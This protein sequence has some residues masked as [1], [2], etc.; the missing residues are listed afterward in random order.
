[1]A[2]AARLLLWLYLLGCAMSCAH[3]AEP[4]AATLL[5]PEAHL[6][7]A[8]ALFDQG[9]GS[10]AAEHLQVVLELAPVASSTWLAGYQ[11]AMAKRPDLFAQALVGS[12][13]PIPLA[14]L[15]EDD[16]AY[17][18]D[19]LFT[20]PPL[21][22]LLSALDR[23]RRD[24]VRF[25]LKEGKWQDAVHIIEDFLAS[26]VNN[27]PGLLL[28]ANIYERHD[29]L[30]LAQTRYD[31]VV[32]KAG[33]L[34]DKTAFASLFGIFRTQYRRQDFKSAEA[35]LA[36]F[37]R[38]SKRHLA[39]ALERYRTSKGG[40]DALFTI[41]LEGRRHMVEGLNALGILKAFRRNNKEA[42][43][44]FEQAR[45][46]AG[47]S[48]VLSLNHAILM[49]RLLI[50][51][52]ARSVL[53]SAGSGLEGL[54][55]ALL[56]QLDRSL[57]SGIVDLGVPLTFRELIRNLQA[58]VRVRQA[59]FEWHFQNEK[60]VAA[61]LLLQAANIA[62]KSAPA[63]YYYGL[64]LKEDDRLDDAIVQFRTALAVAPEGLKLRAEA[65]KRIDEIFE[66]QALRVQQARTRDDQLKEHF[67]QKLDPKQLQIL[68]RD[69]AE[70]VEM[71]QRGE[72]PKAREY[73]RRLSAFHKDNLE[74]YRN[75]GFANQEMGFFKEALA[76][77]DQ[78]L[79]INA[80]DPWTISQ[81]AVALYDYQK[82]LPN[83]LD[84]AHQAIR[85]K[86]DDAG[87]MANLGW[88][89]ALSGD[90]RQGA[91]ILETA[92]QKAPKDPRAHFRLAMVYYN[93]ALYPFALT[94]FS[95]TVVL[96]PRHGPANVFLG[97]TL[98]RLGKVSDAIDQL[99]RSIERVKDDPN[100][101]QLVQD[102]LILLKGGTVSQATPGVKLITDP[103]KAL[104][105]EEVARA[106]A[107]NARLATARDMIVKGEV[108]PAREIILN[109]HREFPTAA[110]VSFVYAFLLMQTGKPAD[111]AEAKS[112]L[113]GMV[114]LNSHEARAYHSLAHLL[115][116]EGKLGEFMDVMERIQ[117]LPDGLSFSDTLEAIAQ[118]WNQVLDLNPDDE[119]VIEPLALVRLHQGRLLEARDLLAKM[120]APAGQ[121]LL[122]E[123]LV[124][125]YVKDRRP[126]SF[127]EAKK[128]LAAG[129]YPAME[130]LDALWTRVSNPPI[131]QIEQVVTKEIRQLPA[132]EL[133][134]WWRIK[135]ETKDIVHEQTKRVAKIDMNNT[136]VF[137]R[138]WRQIDE[139]RRRKVEKVEAAKFRQMVDAQREAAELKERESQERI[140]SQIGGN[141]QLPRAP[142]S[143]AIAPPAAALIIPDVEE[144]QGKQLK[145]LALQ[146]VDAGVSMVAAGHVSDAVAAFRAALNVDPRS[147]EATLSLCLAQVISGQG[148]Q[149]RPMLKRATAYRDT[150]L[151]SLL[152]GHVAWRAGD[153]GTAARHWGA[154]G[155]PVRGKLK[156]AVRVAPLRYFD[157][158]RKSWE[159]VL[160]T[161]PGDVDAT[162]NLALLDFFSGRVHE[163]MSRLEEV[164][165]TPEGAP[166]YAEVVTFQALRTRD[167]GVLNRAMATLAAVDTPMATE[168]SKGL[169]AVAANK[170]LWP[171]K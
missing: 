88:L 19:E 3:A 99:S 44:Y 137:N 73:F 103:R 47:G 6:T 94:K 51:A 164:A 59:L 32:R 23:E 35:V 54:E 9:N 142:P 154:H 75:L 122:G 144:A 80:D 133:D 134:G 171:R 8:R 95:D 84:L 74:I 41:V 4:S 90:T 43:Y 63:H 104:T 163:A 143:P 60:R 160:A 39:D 156:G 130:A 76:A 18:P 166:V 145:A 89:V 48:I 97:L 65:K 1:M 93:Q 17:S 29:Q 58:A 50:S 13:F 140:R 28:V 141:E 117:G 22:P 14:L 153:S 101:S 67:E 86:N 55:Q 27:I 128:A 162:L 20:I 79:K 71:L 96:N 64:I 149:A 157:V 165:A 30:A 78:A 66:T 116:T 113:T 91:Q 56:A 170:N 72:Y 125:Q 2:I 152:L 161:S 57:D 21:A 115:F 11:L 25:L 12:N 151:A 69:V 135:P 109:A 37:L 77:Y 52:G 120:K 83:A 85:I 26:Q 98:A 62:E 124:R 46:L 139:S 68:R 40:G 7:Q 168:L 42:L 105:K 107:A 119:S 148:E 45:L 106:N 36:R 61:S 49:Q 33:M 5:D 108:T 131:S 53:D 92:I 31:E 155:K 34:D 15:P 118:R 150:E 167:V 110:E 111:L 16:V 100:L 121:V 24:T 147:E 112:V 138:R 132:K 146:Q 81:K 126:L 169:S 70:G 158:S 82:D 123:V 102:N 136:L 10:A 114:D 38:E 87:I 127:Q 129:N 159:Q